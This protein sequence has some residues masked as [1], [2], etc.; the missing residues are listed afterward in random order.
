MRNKAALRDFTIDALPHNRA[1]QFGDLLKTRFSLMFC[2]GGVFLLFAVPFLLSFF[3]KYLYVLPAA[4]SSLSPEDYLLFSNTTDLVF[5][6]I[7]VLCFFLFALGLAGSARVL[8]QWVWGQGVYFW[9]DFALGIKQNW[10]SYL[11]T[12]FLFGAIRT[13]ADFLGFLGSN[14]LWANLPSWIALLLIP[15]GMM[16][17]SF[18][19]LYSASYPKALGSSFSYLMKKPLAVLLFFLFPLGVMSLEL[20]PLPFV[21]FIAYVVLFFAVFPFFILGWYLFCL[22]LF[23]EF[24][25]KAY[26]PEYFH[27]GL[28]DEFSNK[29]P[30]KAKGPND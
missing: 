22:S 15:W 11:L 28:A 29:A 26:Y 19:S 6:G 18:E 23:D 5:D 2:F 20:I 30:L 3:I 12:A 7:Y 10:K 8:R 9:H 14:W 4:E 27:R 24:T 21:Q 25:N 16:L 1:Q 17:L 13:L